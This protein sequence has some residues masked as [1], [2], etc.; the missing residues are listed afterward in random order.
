MIVSHKHKFIFLKSR[1][2][3]GTS[4][5]INLA[6]NCGSWD[7]VTPIT[8]FWAKQDETPYEHCPR[9]RA[10]CYNHMP[11]A[12]VQEHVGSTCWEDYFRFTIVR[13][14]WDL[15]VSQFWWKQRGMGSFTKFVTT[16]GAINRKYYFW[17]D[18]SDVVD[19][20]M[21]YEQLEQDYQS[22]CDRFGFPAVELPRTKSLVRQDTRHYSTYYDRWSRAHIARVFD[23][24]IE[25]FGYKFEEGE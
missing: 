22:I 9:N 14:P 8:R 6:A 21:R 1:K 23:V 3:G 7:I 20:Y 5:E 25:R 2:T 18:G 19:Y 13:N 10:G 17:P 12:L 16:R 11:P 15:I 24:E 4:V